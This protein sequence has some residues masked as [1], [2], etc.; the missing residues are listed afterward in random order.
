MLLNMKG[1]RKRTRMTNSKSDGL[2]I[3][4]TPKEQDWDRSSWKKSLKVNID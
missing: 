2:D 1:K 3:F 4:G